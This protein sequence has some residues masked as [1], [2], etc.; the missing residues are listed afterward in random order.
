VLIEILAACADGS[1]TR[2][3]ELHHDWAL[4]ARNAFDA[5]ALP[6]GY[7]SLLASDDPERAANSYGSNAGR[8]IR[9]KRDYDPDN[10]FRSAILLPATASGRR[11]LNH[12]AQ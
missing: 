11:H 10:V 1:N 3:A 2:Q 5:I 4:A 9:A 7:P 6:G 8:L 12:A